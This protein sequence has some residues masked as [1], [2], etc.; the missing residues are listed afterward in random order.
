MIV[1]LNERW[2][3]TVIHPS[4]RSVKADVMLAWG[5][6]LCPNRFMNHCQ[7]I[8]WTK[9]S[10]WLALRNAL[11]FNWGRFWLLFLLTGFRTTSFIV[12]IAQVVK[13]KRVLLHSAHEDAQLRLCV[14]DWHFETLNEVTKISVIALLSDLEVLLRVQSNLLASLADFLSAHNPSNS[15]S[16]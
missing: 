5:G 10:S 15:P 16:H 11:L 1:Q 6:F 12:R 2:W 7:P 4:R 8:R 9:T 14:F 13:P 3:V